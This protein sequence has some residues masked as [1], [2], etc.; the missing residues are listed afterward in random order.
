MKP[1][2]RANDGRRCSK[3]VLFEIELI[4]YLKANQLDINSIFYLGIK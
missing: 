3:N 1:S 4:L 2:A